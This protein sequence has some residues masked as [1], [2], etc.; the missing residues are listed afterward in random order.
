VR[1]VRTSLL[2]LAVSLLLPAAASALVQPSLSV[3]GSDAEL[4]GE[5]HAAATLSNGENPTG[6]ITFEAFG[7]GDPTCQGPSVFDDSAEVTGNGV[8]TTG[9]TP[10]SQLG[11]YHWSAEY[12]GDG[13]NEAASSLCIGTSTVTQATPDLSSTAIDGTAGGLISDSATLSAGFSPT[14]TLTF[15]QRRRELAL[16]RRRRDLDGRQSLAL[17]FDLGDERHGRRHDQRHGDDLRRRQPDRERRLQSL[18][19]R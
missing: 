8:Y 5:I 17:D 1:L 14:G 18:R 6:T 9:N 13:E 19:P 7:P 3:S 15:K 11:T 16:Q 4:G 12:S 2:L 10:A